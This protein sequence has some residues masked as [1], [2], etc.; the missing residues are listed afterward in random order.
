MLMI[1]KLLLIAVFLF[2]APLA[3]ASSNVFQ[4]TVDKPMD[5]VYSKVYEALEKAG[6]W[7]VFE[8][9]IGKNISRFAEKW[10]DNYNRNQLSGIRSM[11]FCNGWYANAVSNADPDML[12]LCPLRMT[13]IEKNGKT[14]ALFARPT[15]IAGNSPAQKL[16][17]RIED[18]IIAVIRDAM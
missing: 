11:V 17:Q 2:S 6:Y 5:Q 3:A 7:V 16:L 14:T 18:E 4:H 9:N 1:K 10:G 13:L 12:A 8:A 15:V